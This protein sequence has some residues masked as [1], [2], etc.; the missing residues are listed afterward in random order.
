MGTGLD[1]D[2]RM[3]GGFSVTVGHAVVPDDEWSRRGAAALVKLLALAEG[4]RLHREQVFD[5]LWPDVPIDVAGPRLHKAA[6]FARR[7]LGDDRPTLRLQHNLVELFPD[8]EVSI[9][10]LE[11]RRLAEAA[12]ATAS[13]AD[14]ERAL[15]WYAGQLLPM[16]LYEPWT[17]QWRERLTVLHEEL[18]RLTERWEELLRANPADEAAHLALATAYADRGDRRAALRQ[19]E[20]MDQALRRELGTVPSEPARQLR[21][22]LSG[23]TGRPTSTAAKRQTQALVGRRKIGDELRARLDRADTGRGSAM[24]LSGPAGVGKTALL[25]LAASL[26]ARRGWRIARGGASAVEGAWPYAPVLEAFADLCRGHP[27]L[28]DG[29]DDSFRME[30]ERALGGEQVT[31]SGETA[32]QRL[33][34]A[35]AELLRLAASGHGLLLVVDDVHEAD[36]ASLRLLHYLARCAVSEQVVIAL[37]ARPDARPTFNQMRES[38]V[39]R[40][41]GGV[42][43][44]SPLD[45]VATRRLV[46]KAFPEFDEDTVAEIWA[47]SHGLPFRALEAARSAEGGTNDVAVSGLPGDALAAFRRVALIGSTFSTDELLAVSGVDEDDTYRHLE[48]ALETSVV[49]PTDAGY[50]FRHELVRQALLS[51]FSAPERTRSGHEVAE[52]L[53]ALGAPPGRVA[54]LFISAGHTVQA[55]PYALPAIE[56]A[57]ALGAYRDGLALVDAVI[58]HATGVDRGHLLARRGDLLMALGDM[59]AVDAYRGALSITSGTEHRLVRVRLAR[60][61]TFQGDLDTAAAALSGLELRGDAADAPLLL[62]RGN[63]AYFTGDV[64]A[65]WEAA[66]AARNLL[67]PDDPWQMVDMVS[68]QGLIA[69][70]RGEWFERFRQELRRTKGN[71]AIAAA[72]F[73]AHLCVAEYLLYGP[74]PYD[75]VI[76]L[77]EDLRRRAE[78]HYRALRGVAF[79]TALIGEAALL[80]GDLDT[81]ERELQEAAD[82]HRELDA[83]A[84]EAHSL[85][86]LAEVRVA[87]GDRAGA[88]E[89]LHKA[90]PLARWSVISN[91]LLQRIYGTMINAADDATLAVSVVEQ[92]EAALGETDRCTFC[93]VMFAVP[94]AIAYADA[95][96]VE[97]AERYLVEAKISG[98]RWEGTAWRAAVAE[99]R[100][101]V[102]AARGDQDEFDRWI[103]TAADLFSAAGQPLD[104]NRCSEQANSGRPMTP[105]SGAL[106][107]GT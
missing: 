97:Q 59:E 44:V 85:Q 64:D 100:A 96:D 78:H 65:A 53:A 99:V 5:A 106:P 11:F 8:A 103:R 58:D 84:G 14:A 81:A 40:G 83:A 30:L 7:A 43:E 3:L 21:E 28:L 68:L 23:E 104:A 66:D 17:T 69:H 47:V 33:F 62:A 75:E 93:D 80:K 79:A 88:V 91:H 60:A 18:L 32:H 20:R 25:D 71:P 1:V 49:E 41:I 67:Q 34:V 61:A 72:V 90:L 35:A 107:L 16:D 94:A 95:G 52:Q 82:L 92:A 46:A 24:V 37:A 31:W 98:R 22:Q 9:D 63:L 55:I 51:T 86:R 105:V 29:L 2:I 89:L 48:A 87:R 54:H 76:E 56:T 101:H 6:H 26:A 38:L 45:E 57:G 102:A 12:V 73:D 39:A 13:Q 10:A 42:V 70:Q 27:A 4:R 15:Q 36:E 19:L 74:I 77:A 50:R